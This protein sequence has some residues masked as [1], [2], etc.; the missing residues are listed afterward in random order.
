VVQ[1]LGRRREQSRRRLLA[2]H[3]DRSTR[4]LVAIMLDAKSSGAIVPEEIDAC[5]VVL[6]TWAMYLDRWAEQ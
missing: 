1:G 5:L 6:R 2:E 4:W 3:A